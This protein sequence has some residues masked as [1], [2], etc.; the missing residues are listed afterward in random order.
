[1]KGRINIERVF[2]MDQQL[3]NIEDHEPK[4]Q[5][6]VAFLEQME[7]TTDWLHRR[8]AF[9][10]TQVGKEI[11]TMT[12]AWGSIGYLFGKPTLTVMVRKSR[13]TTQ[14]LQA[15]QEFTVSVPFSDDMGEKL[16]ACGTQSGRTVDKISTCQLTLLDSQVIA[17]PVIGNC[18]RYYECKV[19]VAQEITAPVLSQE[20]RQEH[21]I[22]GDPYYCYIGEI[23]HC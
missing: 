19:I 5:M 16:F 22:E 8:G 2:L 11:N 13:H 14:L 18:E 10:T 15:S 4:N 3:R 12:I 21:V 6:P 23:V 7:L 1:M 9:L 20:I 17:T